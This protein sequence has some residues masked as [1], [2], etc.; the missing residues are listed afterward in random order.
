MRAVAFLS[1]ALIWIGVAA[2]ILIIWQLE[3]D[4]LNN[5]SSDNENTSINKTKKEKKTGKR[6]LLIPSE[7]IQEL[8]QPITLRNFEGP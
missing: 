5:G 4:A 2:P 8:M 7:G 1:N 6:K 3:G